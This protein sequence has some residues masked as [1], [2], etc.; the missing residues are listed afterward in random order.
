MFT[1]P[2]QTLT[3]VSFSNTTST[4]PNYPA[5]RNITNVAYTLY[6]NTT[7]GNSATISGR[8]DTVNQVLD[9]Q[10]IIDNTISTM[11]YNLNLFFLVYIRGKTLGLNIPRRVVKQVYVKGFPRVPN[12]PNG[13]LSILTTTGPQFFSLSAMIILVICMYSIVLEKE[14]KLRFGMQMM[15]LRNVAYWVSWFITFAV[16]ALIQVLITIAAGTY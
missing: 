7:S 16:V 9:W 14:Q 2:N 1:N 4:A 15:G 3:A 8:G 10:S 12:R 11:C 6:Y 5:S 13:Q